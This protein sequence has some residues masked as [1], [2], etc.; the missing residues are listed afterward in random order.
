MCS[1]GTKNFHAIMNVDREKGV[2]EAESQK[3]LF[4]KF[5]ERLPVELESQRQALMERLSKA[6]SLWR[7]GE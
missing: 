1:F 6:P 4:D 3:E 5:E 2:T 7:S